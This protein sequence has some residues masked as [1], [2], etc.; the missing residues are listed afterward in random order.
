ML[1]LMSNTIHIKHPEKYL[2]ENINVIQ[3]KFLLKENSIPIV[4]RLRNFYNDPFLTDFY[5]F[6]E[7]CRRISVDIDDE[8]RI[9]SIFIATQKKIDN[10]FFVALIEQYGSLTKMQ[11]MGSVKNIEH[12]EE[13]EFVSSKTIGEIVNCQFEDDPI[14]IIWENLE[15]KIHIQMDSD[16]DTSLITFKRNNSF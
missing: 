14:F 13:K 5:F 6:N 3:E 15:F 2:N 4:N 8:D 1:T 11:K 12:L 7:E 10:T 9:V 16:R